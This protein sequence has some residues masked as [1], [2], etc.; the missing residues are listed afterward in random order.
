M[1]IRNILLTIAVSLDA[2]HAEGPLFIETDSTWDVR[3]QSQPTYSLAKKDEKAGLVFGLEFQIQGKGFD[4]LDTEIQRM[5]DGYKRATP[6]PKDVSTGVIQGQ[7]VRGAFVK[8]TRDES[9]SPLDGPPPFQTIFVIEHG[10][11]KWNGSYMGPEADWEEALKILSSIRALEAEEPLRIETDA[12]PTW[13]I[14]SQIT[15]IYVLKKKKESA[16]SLILYS[17]VQAQGKREDVAAWIKTTS[18]DRERKIPSPKD[19]STGVIMGQ[20]V[21]GGFAKENIAPDIVRTQIMI[22]HENTRWTGSYTGSETT[23]NETLKIL[24]SIKPRG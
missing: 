23:W 11:A 9:I 15:P 16:S 19:A 22:D 8:I 2:L 13:E 7:S 10:N 5:S 24:S 21:S 17:Q 6:P 14:Q 12:A 20:L 4:D 3:F 1:K 18:D